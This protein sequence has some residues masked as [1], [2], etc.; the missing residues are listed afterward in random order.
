MIPVGAI[1]PPIKI[2]WHSQENTRK[3]NKTKYSET[4]MILQSKRKPLSWWNQTNLEQ[5]M[6][7]LLLGLHEGQ[8]DPSAS[9]SHVQVLRSDRIQLL[10]HSFD[11]WPFLGRDC[12]VKLW[13][14]KSGLWVGFVTE[15]NG[16]ML[17]SRKV[18]RRY[19]FPGKKT[20]LQ[21]SESQ[22]EWEVH[23]YGH[24]SK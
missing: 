21:W 24:S 15:N 2:H 19:G 6:I 3:Q 5:A 22:G 10:A 1:Y 8:T 11:W 23:G 7:K 20:E 17:P 16:L 9:G 13:G 4:D 12:K 18:D 14:W